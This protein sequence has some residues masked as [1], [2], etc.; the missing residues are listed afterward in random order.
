MKKCL[1]LIVI[2]LVAVSL[3]SC[4]FASQDQTGT[5]AFEYKKITAEQAKER[6]DSGD[7]IIIL[8]VRTQEEYDE[9]HIEGAI[10]IPN[11]TI[12]DT[13]PELLPDLNAEILVYC[14]SGNRSAQAA[15]KLIDIGYTNVFDFGGIID[16]PYETI[17]E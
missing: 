3:V 14:R 2:L 7:D 9:E 10:L 16:W 11:E 6:I 8:D 15:N 5:S 12:S 17:T 1:S 13:Q 4:S